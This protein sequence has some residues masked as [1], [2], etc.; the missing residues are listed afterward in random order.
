MNPQSS[1]KKILIALVLLVGAL[2]IVLLSSNPIR[3]NVGDY[4]NLEEKEN[5]EVGAIDGWLITKDGFEIHYVVDWIV[6]PEYYCSPGECGQGK[7]HLVGYEFMLPSGARIWWGGH[8]SSCD[9]GEDRGPRFNDFNYGVS[10]SACVKGLMSG[11]SMPGEAAVS[12]QDKNTFG[13]F[14]VKNNK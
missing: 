3:S 2:V 11:I 9:N 4:G 13:D 8:Q 10:S 14:V 5:E 12:Q 6:E 1:N 7:R